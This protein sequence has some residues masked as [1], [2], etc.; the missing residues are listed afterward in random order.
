[1]ELSTPDRH[2]I[3]DLPLVSPSSSSLANGDTNGRPTVMIVCLIIIAVCMVGGVLTALRSVI[4]PVLIG[5]F[6]FLLINPLVSFLEERRIP[7]WMAYLLIGLLALVG[8]YAIGLSVQLQAEAFQERWPDYSKQ[9]DETVNTYARL[10]GVVGEKETFNWRR[11]GF[12]DLM[13]I[14]Q[15]E[16]F[17]HVFG[18]TLEAV[19]SA[20]LAVFYLLFMLIEARRLRWRTQHSL[21]SDSAAKVLSIVSKINVDIWRYLVVK[22]VVS[23]GLGVSTALTCLAFGLEFWPLWGFLMFVANYVTYVGSILA[24]AP[25]ILI[26]FLQFSNPVYAGVIAAVLTAVR[27]VWID[28]V[29]IR[30]SG[31]HVN[32]TPLLLLFSLAL[33]G[34]MWGVVG[35][36]LAIPLVTS[37]RIAL[38][39]NAETSFLARLM[40]D[41]EE[42]AHIAENAEI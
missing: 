19:E 13:P 16:M 30:Y 26:A 22:T 28:F 1:M 11:Y 18:M 32:V 31:M 41:G 7:T 2:E 24:L 38:D 9:F 34:W 21:E 20:A 29:E 39:S 15:E 3:D 23:V 5:L 14:K 25:P 40:S 35:M 12:R 36:L 10:T 17:T 6:L 4:T 27:F 42:E 37:L 33:L 8:V